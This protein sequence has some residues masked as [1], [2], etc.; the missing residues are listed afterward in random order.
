MKSLLVLCGLLGLLAFTA[1]SQ[2]CEVQPVRVVIPP[3]PAVSLALKESGKVVVRT[4]IDKEGNVSR[5]EAV[6]GPKWLRKSAE[7]VA[8]VWKFSTVK[9]SETSTCKTRSADLTFDYVVLPAGTRPGPETRSYFVLPF[10]VTIQEILG[11]VTINPTGKSARKMLQ[12]P[13]R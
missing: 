2:T 6:E 13:A 7:E 10:H 9:T 11:L 5:S 12:K 8:K 1:H 3:F 4:T